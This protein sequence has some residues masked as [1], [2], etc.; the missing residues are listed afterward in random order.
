MITES[1]DIP[2]NVEVWLK[3]KSHIIKPTVQH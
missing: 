1:G 3:L 2:P